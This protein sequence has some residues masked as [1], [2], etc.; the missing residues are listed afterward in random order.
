[1]HWTAAVR[2]PIPTTISLKIIN[3]VR[4]AVANT[5]AAANANRWAD[6]P[7]G[8]EIMK[9]EDFIKHGSRC[10][11]GKYSTM[12]RCS[13]GAQAALEELAA[14]RKAAQPSVH[15]TAL[16]VRE[17]ETTCPNCNLVFDVPVPEPHSG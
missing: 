16:N 13:C 4:G 6:A 14:L 10:L 2:T 12:G 15:P 7:P 5:A 8:K 9:I 3:S 1:M 11:A 17:I